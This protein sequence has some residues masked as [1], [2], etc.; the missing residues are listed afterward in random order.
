MGL[1]EYMYSETIFFGKEEFDI[2]R[3]RWMFEDDDFL[4][5]K[6][7][8]ALDGVSDTVL[9]FGAFIISNLRFSF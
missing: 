9:M 7:F 8:I 6:F 2:L 1:I 4:K 3:R 5:V